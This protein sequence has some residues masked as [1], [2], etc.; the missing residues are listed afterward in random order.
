MVTYNILLY[1]LISVGLSFE[2]ILY[3][4]ITFGD[5]PLY[6]FGVKEHDILSGTLLKYK[7]FPYEITMIDNHKSE[8]SLS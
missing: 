1:Y 2:N 5:K 4:S 8:R 6:G 3:N 7:W